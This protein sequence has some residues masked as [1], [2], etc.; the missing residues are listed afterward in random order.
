MCVC[1]YLENS[2]FVV[3][4]YEYIKIEFIVDLRVFFSISLANDPLVVVIV[5][6]D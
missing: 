2:I 6:D 3:K 4:I 5:Y 1:V